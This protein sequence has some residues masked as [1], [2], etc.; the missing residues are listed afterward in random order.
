MVYLLIP[1]MESCSFGYTHMTSLL[2]TCSPLTYSPPPAEHLMIP[3]YF[4]T[5]SFVLLLCLNMC[6]PT[7]CPQCP[8]SQMVCQTKLCILPNLV[9]YANTV[10]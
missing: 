7:W 5:Y 9:W 3:Q 2:C 10:Y 8:Q 6:F 1:N 4:P